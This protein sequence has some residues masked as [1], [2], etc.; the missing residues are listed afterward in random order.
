MHTAIYKETDWSEAMF[1]CGS[2]PSLLFFVFLVVG[3]QYLLDQSVSYHIFFIELNM[4]NAIDV[5]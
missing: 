4:A 2:G 3:A 5:L 1:C